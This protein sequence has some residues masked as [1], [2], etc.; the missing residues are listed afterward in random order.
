MKVLQN[1]F[2]I[3][4]IVGVTIAIGFYLSSF[5]YIAQG[6]APSGLPANVATSS[7]ATLDQYGNVQVIRSTPN[8]NARVVTVLGGAGVM[9]SLGEKN[10]SSTGA[11]YGLASSTLSATFGHY[12]AGSTTVAYDSGIYGCG[13]WYGFGFATTTI[14]VTEL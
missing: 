1:I 14:T 2:A 5:T 8:C 4:A 6:S 11:E 3:L 10:A 9:L 13:E 12:Q 7:T